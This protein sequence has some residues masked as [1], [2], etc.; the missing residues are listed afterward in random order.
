MME[1][2]EAIADFSLLGGP[3]YRLGSDMK[4]LPAYLSLYQ[5]NTCV[6][7]TKG[8]NSVEGRKSRGKAIQF[9]KSKQS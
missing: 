8:T 3:L 9:N 1:T 2:R 5:I 6:W 7:L 4:A